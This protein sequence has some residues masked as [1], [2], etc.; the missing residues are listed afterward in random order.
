[1]G[2]ISPTSERKPGGSERLSGLAE[3]TQ[4]VTA[5]PGLRGAPP[6]SCPLVLSS[7]SVTMASASCVSPAIS[8]LRALIL[9]NFSPFNVQSNVDTTGILLCD[10][11]KE[12]GSLSL[13]PPVC[14]MDMNPLPKQAARGLKCKAETHAVNC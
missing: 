10:H 14:G 8:A 13:S 12:T 6:S 1:M 2:T 4:L 5:E 11:R 9:F 7:Y 3:V